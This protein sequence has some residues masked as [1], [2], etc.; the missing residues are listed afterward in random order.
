MNGWKKC[1]LKE[2]ATIKS[3]K[4][5]KEYEVL[6]SEN[7]NLIPYYKVS[8]LDK[9]DL[10]ESMLYVN[11][12]DIQDRDIVSKHILLISTTG[13]IGDLGITSRD[14]VINNNIKAIKVDEKIILTEY[15]MNY[16]YYINSH[17]QRIAK[18]TVIPFLSVKDLMDLEIQYPSLI[19][20]RKLNEQLVF[21]FNLKKERLKTKECITK[22]INSKIESIVKIENHTKSKYLKDYYVTRP[23]TGLDVR[24]KDYDVTGEIGLVSINK[25]GILNSEAINDKTIHKEIVKSDEYYLRFNDILITRQSSVGN[26]GNSIIL[27]DSTK[28]ITYNSHIFKIDL[29]KSEL[30]PEVFYLWS[31]TYLVQ[32]YI[33]KKSH[34]TGWNASIKFTDLDHIPVPESIIRNQDK[35]VSLF[36]VYESLNLEIE[37]SLQ[38]I[39][40]LIER[41]KSKMLFNLQEESNIG[42]ILDYKEI[43]NDS[44]TISYNHEYEVLTIGKQVYTSYFGN[45]EL[46]IVI[47]NNKVVN[48]IGLNELPLNQRFKLK[49]YYDDGMNIE[50]ADM[51]FLSFTLV[52]GGKKVII[53]EFVPIESD[54]QRNLVDNYIDLTI[55]DYIYKVNQVKQVFNITN[56]ESIINIVKELRVMNKKT[57]YSRYRRFSESKKEFLKLLS[58]DQLKF[59]E[60][61][62]KAPKPL[63]VHEAYKLFLKWNKLDKNDYSLHEFIN[64]TKMLNNFGLIQKEFSLYL[65]YPQIDNDESRVIEIFKESQNIERWIC[66]S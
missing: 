32:D 58:S 44:E 62:L 27:R 20:Q 41:F 66:T 38:L 18:K 15:L 7:K 36:K 2:I 12:N 51:Y 5:Y 34:I 48:T 53:E 55:T 9:R 14:I 37:R 46:P 13:T 65:N 17:L 59:Y 49:D 30:K 33:R 40:L 63:A 25:S 24:T 11:S 39:E 54:V 8:D 50:F 47:D 28:S 1:R 16:L 52:D 19:V 21:I 45:K 29:S 56:F 4:S 22:I 6:Y 10:K 60:V 23:K 57:F 42:S 61:F 43:D 26:L 64:T 31:R 35:I 3:G